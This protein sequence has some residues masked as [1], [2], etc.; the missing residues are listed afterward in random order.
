M[1]VDSSYEK[2]RALENQIKKF[3]K[4]LKVDFNLN[5]NFSIS[6]EKES[7]IYKICFK[8]IHNFFAFQ[9]Y[10]YNED[11]LN[12]NRVSYHLD[13]K[14]FSNF[15]NYLKKINVKF[16]PSASFR[17]NNKDYAFAIDKVNYNNKK[18]TWIINTNVFKNIDRRNIIEYILMKITTTS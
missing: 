12:N 18:M 4:I 1:V 5:A 16:S 9:I 17:I 6:K 2:Q 7:G 8:K 11:E 10:V 13:A 15:Y 3:I 14:R